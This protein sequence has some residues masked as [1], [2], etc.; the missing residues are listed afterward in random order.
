MSK[1]PKP[2]PKTLPGV[3]LPQ[4]V[5]C[6]KPNCK[7]ASGQKD[8]LHGPY[9]YRFWREDGR[10]RKQYVPLDRVDAVRATCEQRQRLEAKRRQCRH[11][12]M[13]AFRQLSDALNPIED[14]I[15]EH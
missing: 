14:A 8:D 7:C 9:Y 15:N 1:T 6:G 10:L 2:L 13:N 11:Q 4:M 5:R 3:V 12:W